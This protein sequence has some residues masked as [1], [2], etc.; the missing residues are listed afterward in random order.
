M[1]D[2]VHR[3]TLCEAAAAI[4][5]R[6]LSSVEVVQA[7]IERAERLQ[8][9]L[10]AFISLDGDR[11]LDAADRADAS[12]ARGEAV[13]P[14]HG[15]PVAHKDM[16][17]RAGRTVTCGSRL[18]RDFV[19]D[20]TATVLARLDR[21]GAIDLGGLNMSEFACNPFGMNVL[22]GRARNP[23]NP[24]CIA[25]GS[26]S[27]SGAAVAAG[28]V[29]GSFGSDTGGSV[30]LPAG[31]CG[32]AGLLPTNGR[33]S[34]YGVMPL[35][36]SLD[37]AGPLA[38]TVRDCA[39]LT[40]VT[41]G[42]DPLDPN[43]A[44]STVPDYEAALE[45][46][47]EGLRVGVP[48]RHHWDGLAADVKTRL[49]AS[50]DVFRTLGADIVEVVPPDPRPLDSLANLIILSEAAAIHRRWLRDRAEDY[51]PLVRDRIRFGFSFPAAR[52]VEALSLRG[53]LLNR[54]LDAV[55][56]T[57]D[58]LH[59]PLLAQPVPTMAAVEA[60]L[61]GGPDLSFN[62]AHNTRLFNYLGLPALAIPCGFD[63]AGLPVSFQL[64]GPPFAETRLFNAGHA[65]QTATEF[66]RQAPGLDAPASVS[67]HPGSNSQRCEPPPGSRP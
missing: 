28:L 16:F 64:A 13:G 51:T 38:R 56:S 62:V 55:F 52:Y 32:V 35:S 59:V 33:I 10:N 65:F 47:V 54:Y 4:R 49:E 46:P 14:L 23:W 44:G 11:A 26:S 3:L 25:G 20:H 29:Y 37:N 8:P 61:A 36:F 57:V 66:H 22:C 60:E 63:D 34:R 21:A 15:V 39:R 27:G 24:E 7:A 41:A 12:L 5:D 31:I 43:S 42:I 9:R 18:R 50:L 48:I 17:Y 30:R 1:S 53:S 40:H 2:P 19:P 45:S 58:V 6:R 67:S